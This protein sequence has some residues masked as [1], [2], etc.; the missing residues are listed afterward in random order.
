MPLVFVHG[1]SNRMGDEYRKGVATRDALFRRYLLSGHSR[2]DGQ[3]VAICNPYWGDKGGR[4]FWDGASLPLEDFEILGSGGDLSLL[5]LY[6]TARPDGALSQADRA[7][8][9]VA[10][11]SLPDA[12]DLL[13]GAGAMEH[14]AEYEGADALAALGIE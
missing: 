6:A 10:R 5:N 13:W 2:S 7:V 11:Q 14:G 9:D 4:L 1:V 12:V 8:L 3:E